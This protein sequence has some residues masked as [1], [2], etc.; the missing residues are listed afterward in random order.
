MVSVMDLV[1]V[2]LTSVVYDQILVLMDYP[3]GTKDCSMFYTLNRQTV[4]FSE[5][6]SLLY[7]QS[8]DLSS[9]FIQLS[10]LLPRSISS[11]YC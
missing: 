1:R 10:R 6:V 11:S 8:I 3:E 9:I 2:G 4:A 7:S 5:L